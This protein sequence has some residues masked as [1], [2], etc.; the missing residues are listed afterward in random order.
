MSSEDL[1]EAAFRLTLD[2]YTLWNNGE[3]EGSCRTTYHD[4]KSILS[5][6]IY[7]N[8]YLP[9]GTMNTHYG[10]HTNQNSPGKCCS[11]SAVSYI[12]DL[13]GYGFRFLK[14]LYKHWRHHCP[15]L[16]THFPPLGMDIDNRR[17]RKMVASLVRQAEVVVP[18]EVM[19]MNRDEETEKEFELDD[20]EDEDEEVLQLKLINNNDFCLF[21]QD[22]RSCHELLHPLIAIGISGTLEITKNIILVFTVIENFIHWED[23]N[24]TMKYST[25]AKN[26]RPLASFVKPLSQVIEFFIITFEMLAK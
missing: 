11:E 12:C 16:L 5:L 14:T 19:K 7:C 17:L 21:R 2:R 25:K 26:D 1:R 24:D 10:V 23:W 18:Y 15:E 3:E 6:C 13:C 9:S 22:F 8:L 4:D 20:D